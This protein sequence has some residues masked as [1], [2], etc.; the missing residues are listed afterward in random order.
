MP[1]DQL[2]TWA[3]ALVYAGA[4][5]AGSLPT[6]LLIA[7]ARGI[8]I[9]AHGSGNIGATNITRVLGKGPG[10]VCFAIDLAKGLL[11]TLAAGM[12]LGR[13][14]EL[15]MPA[16]DAWTWLGAMVMPVLGHIFCPWLK[17]K[18][19]KGV[20][21]GLGVM[22][23]VFPA[24][25][26]PA[27]LTFATWLVV[28]AA[29]RYVSLASIAAGAC[30]PVWTLLTFVLGPRGA[31]GD[32]D[33]GLGPGGLGS[34]DAGP[35]SGSPLAGSMPFLIVSVALGVLVFWTHRSNIRRL[36]AGTEPKAGRKQPVPPP[37][38]AP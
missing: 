30:L 18:G 38:G 10:A 28:F 29:R 31:M 27:A 16:A 19:G 2:P 15:R 7:R 11:P 21:T 13:L 3:W 25:T 36:R 22:L 34:R 5:L 35:A 20:A 26:I 24:M 12:V 33:A 6:G 1:A 17:F 14:G 37:A 32:A 8:D 9:R 4:Y 23:G